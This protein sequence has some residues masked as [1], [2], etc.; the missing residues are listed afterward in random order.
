[1]NR[2]GRLIPRPRYYP[3]LYTRYP[4]IHVIIFTVIITA[5]RALSA[6]RKNRPTRNSRALSRIDPRTRHARTHKHADYLS[7]Y[8]ARNSIFQTRNSRWERL[9]HR[10]RR[11]SV[12]RVNFNLEVIK[13]DTSRARIIDAPE[14]P[15]ERAAPRRRRERKNRRPARR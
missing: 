8:P 13:N 1:M 3:V 7:V 11:L 14:L 2:G 12:A 10:A 5:G 15:R 4:N 6:N 9:L